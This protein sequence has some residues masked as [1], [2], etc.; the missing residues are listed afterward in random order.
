[1]FAAEW[2]L[3]GGARI[4]NGGT[5]GGGG[6]EGEG[7]REREGGRQTEALRLRAE[8]WVMAE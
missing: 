7:E 2:R 8:Q 5:G 6:G 4:N 1:M 3:S